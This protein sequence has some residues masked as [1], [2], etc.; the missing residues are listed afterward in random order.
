MCEAAVEV[1]NLTKRIGSKTIIKGLDFEIYPGEIFGFLGPNGAGK[2]TTIRMMVGLTKITE[3]DVI[4]YGKSIKK[5]FKEAIAQV[6]AIVENPEM[7][8]FMSGW[9]NLLHYAR[10]TPGGVNQDKIEEIVH[11]TGLENVIHKKV[12]TYSLGMRQRLGLAQALLHE[13]S[14]LILDEPT[15]GLDPSGIY[16]IR[17]YLRNLAREKGL[18]IFISSHLLS[19][20]EILCDRVGII[21]NGELISVDYI[22]NFVNAGNETKIKLQ[23]QPID[24]ALRV[25]E[26]KFNLSAIVN[27]NNPWC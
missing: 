15:N 26:Q 8:K 5:Q 14:V 3:G 17:S 1:K 16:E 22:N 23:L 20:V 21:K 27:E 6:G 4:I 13:P 10:M 2:T 9:K 25:L 18:T 7:Y 12:K 19:E 11:L 24:E